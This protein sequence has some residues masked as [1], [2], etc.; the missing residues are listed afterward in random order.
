MVAMSR[1]LIHHDAARQ[2]LEVAATVDEVKEIQSPKP[3][4]LMAAKSTT[5]NL[6]H[7]AQK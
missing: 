5:P 3:F 7:G 2:E 6:R 1:R 4:A